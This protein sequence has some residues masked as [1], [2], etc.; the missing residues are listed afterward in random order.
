VRALDKTAARF[1][2]GDLTTLG[3]EVRTGPPEI[4]ALA[5]S[6]TTMAER[7]ADYL[8]EHRAFVADASHQLRTPLTALRLRL[9]NLQTRLNDAD[10]AELD[11][12][13]DETVR[14]SSLV[15]DLLQLARADRDE[16]PVAT[17][18]LQLT[19]DRLDTW[20]AV[21]DARGVHLALIGGEQHAVVSAVPGAVEQIL[22]NTLDN[23]LRASPPGGE[24]TVWI[25]AIPGWWRLVVGDRGP[26]LSDEDKLRAVRRFWRGDTEGGGS[27]LGLAIAASLATASNGTLQLVDRAGGGLL[28]VVTLPMFTSAAA[29]PRA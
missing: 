26:G 28:I 15:T 27:G 8:A 12:A 2:S 24:V 23:A 18:L 21:A 13:I 3:T 25:E 20:S 4:R 29:G 17:D 6:M 5:A 16:A 10:A 11:T 7:L 1:A 19:T 9:E 22:D 14:L